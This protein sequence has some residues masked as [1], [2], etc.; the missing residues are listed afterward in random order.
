MHEPVR[1]RSVARRSGVRRS[2]TLR[3][4][5]R[6]AR[7]TGRLGAR[8]AAAVRL[9][10]RALG[11]LGAECAA[12]CAANARTVKVCVEALPFQ[13]GAEAGVG[14]RPTSVFRVTA[15]PG[16]YGFEALLALALAVNHVATD[17]PAAGGASERARRHGE[18]SSALVGRT[19]AQTLT[20]ATRALARAELGRLDARRLELLTLLQQSE[21]DEAL[22]RE[23]TR[24]ASTVIL[25]GAKHLDLRDLAR[26]ASDAEET[27]GTVKMNKRARASE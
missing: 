15:R 6:G 5:S 10:E 8:C 11:V 22:A 2:T 1:V 17:A 24:V 12:V 21:C 26:A 20:N 16:D 13:R 9:E 18:V 14:A 7:W 27:R 3:I 19:N 23:A 25:S 4:N